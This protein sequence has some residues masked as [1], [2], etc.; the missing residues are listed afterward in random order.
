MILFI[1]DFKNLKLQILYDKFIIFYKLISL[2]III[3]LKSIFIEL[4]LYRNLLKKK[5]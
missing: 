3:I 2:F 1:F 5:S 4:E